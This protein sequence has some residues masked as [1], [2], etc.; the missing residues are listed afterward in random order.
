MR[1]GKA[2]ILGMLTVFMAAFI[3]AP[4]AKASEYSVKASLHKMHSDTAVIDP[5][6]GED[7]HFL[8]EE[9]FYKDESGKITKNALKNAP[10]YWSW[11]VI[12][13]NDPVNYQESSKL[14]AEKASALTKKLGASATFTDKL[15]TQ[16]LL[17]FPRVNMSEWAGCLVKAE[18]EVLP[19]TASLRFNRTSNYRSYSD[20]VFLDRVWYSPTVKGVY[21]F[22][23]T[24]DNEA[25]GYME[26]P[27]ICDV[28]YEFKTKEGVASDKNDGALYAWMEGGFAVDEVKLAKN[29]EYESF[30]YLWVLATK[31]KMKNQISDS[32]VLEVGEK[33]PVTLANQNGQIVCE[34]QPREVYYLV[35]AN[36]AKKCKAS[37]VPYDLGYNEGVLS[38]NSKGIVTGKKEGVT[39][40][41]V[42]YPDT[43]QFLTY[44]IAVK[45]SAKPVAIKS[46]KAGK[47][48]KTA[49]VTWKK[50]STATGY[51][52]QYASN[53]KFKKAKTITVSAK[54]ASTTLKNLTGKKCFVRIRSYK[55]KSAYYKKTKNGWKNKDQQFYSDW[56]ATKKLIIK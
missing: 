47:K 46:L 2:V 48:S 28:T 50:C 30:D 29:L 26:I 3:Q 17:N 27:V 49:K 25:I 18:F 1:K 20:T 8:W 7:V 54:K 15:K 33:I 4:V 24:V 34:T 19:D 5:N 16:N 43:G 13:D 45:Q 14:T 35:D 51:E 53:S 39:R 42:F 23:I 37:E 36:G 12:N 41:N 9:S 52:I 10:S 22:T 40:I 44:K 56:S 38:V 31:Y 6:K 55:T 11:E 21:K 32:I